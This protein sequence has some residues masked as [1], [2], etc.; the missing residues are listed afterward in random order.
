MVRGEKFG[1]VA[2]FLLCFGN[3][4]DILMAYV[5]KKGR[6]GEKDMRV[7]AGSAKGH[8]LQ[9]IEGLDTRPTTDRIKETLFNILA[10]SLPECVFLDLFSGS[11]AIAI[12]ALSRGAAKAVLVEQSAACQSVIAQNLQHTKLQEK[13]ICLQME[14][15]A[16]LERLTKEKMRF[17]MIYMDP[18]YTAGLEEV[19]LQKIVA[20]NLLQPDGVLIVEHSAKIALP[21]VAG[22]FVER[23]KKYKTT[24]LTFLRLEE[25]AT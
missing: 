1:A 11:G 17:D 2:G 5:K 23:K 20:G 3:E 7:I 19:V 6:M 9:T 24:V 16:A 10:F 8:K 13:A 12:E 25:S 15:C 18:P 22:L 21:D 4:F 14:V